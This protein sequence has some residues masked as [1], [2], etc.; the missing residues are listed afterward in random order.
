MSEIYVNG[1]PYPFS[2][3]LNNQEKA[4]KKKKDIVK[5]KNNEK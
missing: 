1:M 4:K 2:F 3:D 5:T